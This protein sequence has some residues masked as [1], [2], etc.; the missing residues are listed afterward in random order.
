MSEFNLD[1]AS[2]RLFLEGFQSTLP[3][4][5]CSFGWLKIQN[6]TSSHSSEEDL[7]KISN[8]KKALD[9]NL[10]FAMSNYEIKFF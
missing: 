3:S 9:A 5:R 6:S 8:S 2:A 1:I 4:S 7:L 10:Q